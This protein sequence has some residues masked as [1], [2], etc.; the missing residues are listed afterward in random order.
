MLCPLC[1]VQTAP[2]DEQGIM[3][4]QCPQC[5]G[6]W[7]SQIA[8]NR[9]TRREADQPA[10]VLTARGP[11]LPELAERVTQTDSTGQIDCP[12][13]AVT[14]IKERFHPMIPVQIDRCPKCDYIWLD[15]G[16]Q[17]LLLRL[18]RQLMTDDDPAIADKRAKLARIDTLRAAA[19]NDFARDMD[20]TARIANDTLKTDLNIADDFADQNPGINIAV[21]AA[22]F[23]LRLLVR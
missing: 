5:Q 20:R 22:E 11:S 12:Y 15:A 17:D 23:L 3:A 13:C 2:L 21:E 4:A 10:P 1:R 8:L 14:M 18:Y 19:V 16:E 9:L 7:I 6:I